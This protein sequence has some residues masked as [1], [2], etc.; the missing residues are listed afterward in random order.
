MCSSAC[1][2]DSRGSCSIGSDAGFL[3][4]CTRLSSLSFNIKVDPMRSWPGFVTT[5]SDIIS[6]LSSPALESL[7]F[8]IHVEA[9][10]DSP[11]SATHPDGDFAAIDLRSIHDSMTHKLFDS[12]RDVR[13]S[14]FHG[15]DGA[16]RLTCDTMLTA[17]EV[18]RRIRLILDPW[19]KR[20]ILGVQCHYDESTDEELTRMRE[21]ATQKRRNEGDSEQRRYVMPQIY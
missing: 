19:S 10:E 3:T 13:I 15:D 17:K 16:P 8:N 6:D 18:E 5:F 7:I 21:D 9:P 11:F 12:L 2:P 14:V 4:C 1:S 20:G